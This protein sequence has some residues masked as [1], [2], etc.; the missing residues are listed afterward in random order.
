MRTTTLKKMIAAAGECD[1]RGRIPRR[2]AD[3][4]DETR[5]N[6]DECVSFYPCLYKS[7]DGLARLASSL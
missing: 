2:V 5:T 4:R 1:P 7:K 6:K 3:A